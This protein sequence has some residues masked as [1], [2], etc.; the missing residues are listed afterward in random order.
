MGNTTE[1]EKQWRTEG[2]VDAVVALNVLMTL[3]EGAGA[4]P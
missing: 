1:T 4:S 3:D 2:R